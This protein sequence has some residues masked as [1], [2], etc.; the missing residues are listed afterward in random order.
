MSTIINL[1]SQYPNY[2]IE[3]ICY[4]KRVKIMKLCYMWTRTLFLTIF[5]KYN[6]V[7]IIMLFI[8]KMKYINL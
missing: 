6:G 2:V 5:L 8:Y 7:K 1:E 4:F 3:L